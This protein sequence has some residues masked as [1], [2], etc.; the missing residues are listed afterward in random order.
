MVEI[1]RPS[2]A[3]FIGERVIINCTA[4]TV[5]GVSQLPTLNLTHPNGTNLS[6]AEGRVAIVL[7]PVHVTDAGEYTCTGVINLKNIISV[8]VQA[9]R[10]L[11]FKC[12]F[13]QS[14][15]D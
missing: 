12:K 7:D 8:I 3:P 2:V 15:A 1:H 10:N 13:T 11:T 6:S 5:L 4:T 14:I 9:K